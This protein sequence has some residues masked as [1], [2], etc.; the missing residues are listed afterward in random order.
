LADFKLVDQKYII[1]NYPLGRGNFATT[2]L[3]VMKADQTQLL[4]CKMIQKSD[5]L[6]K[7]KN[8]KNAEQRK[9]YIINSLKNEV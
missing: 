6:E 2:Y 3:A 5:I 7:L 9:E 8:S 1:K 4:A